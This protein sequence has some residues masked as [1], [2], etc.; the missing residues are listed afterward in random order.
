M[1]S[2]GSNKVICDLNPQLEFKLTSQSFAL[3]SLLAYLSIYESRL[4]IAASYQDNQITIKQ[5][6]VELKVILVA[7]LTSFWNIM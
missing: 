2:V 4:V 7:L 6:C 1:K 3:I 5:C